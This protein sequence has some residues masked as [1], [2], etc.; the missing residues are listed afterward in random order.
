MEFLQEGLRFP[1]LLL[2]QLDG[3]GDIDLRSVEL[4]VLQLPGQRH[5][6]LIEDRV[7]ASGGELLGELAVECS[8]D[9]DVNAVVLE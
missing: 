1:N 5:R 7:H 6:D 3:V 4:D 8:R 2:S 9:V